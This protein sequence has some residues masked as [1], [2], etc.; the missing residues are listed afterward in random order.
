MALTLRG[1]VP[2]TH[3]FLPILRVL[4]GNWLLL[5]SRSAFFRGEVFFGDLLL[6]MT[7]Q[8]N[9]RPNTEFK[10]CGVPKSTR[11]IDC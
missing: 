3:S 6:G 11:R 2:S 4:K 9:I 1:S 8:N 7:R 5:D 10:R